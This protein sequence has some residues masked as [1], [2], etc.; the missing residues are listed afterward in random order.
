MARWLTAHFFA[1]AEVEKPI[2][3]RSDT[4]LKMIM[5]SEARRLAR[6]WKRGNERMGF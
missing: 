1:T 5:H 6:K 4:C 3:M 2:E